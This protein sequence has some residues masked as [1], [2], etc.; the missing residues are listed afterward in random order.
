METV[1]TMQNERSFNWMPWIVCFSASL[2][3]FYEFIQGNMFASIADNIMQDFNIEVDKLAYLSS[4]YYLSNV[5]FLF[6]AGHLLD[7]YSAKKIMLLAMFLCVVSTFVLAEA[8]SFFI[9]LLC[10]F[11]TGVGSAFCLLGPVRIASRWFL[12]RQMAMVTGIIVTI[13]MLG[14]LAAQYPMTLLVSKIGWRNAVLVVG[15]IGV[16]MWFVMGF[17]I[18][19][20]PNTHKIGAENRLRFKE[21]FK[22]AYTNSAAIRVAL[23]ATLMNMGIA[24]FGAMMGSLYLM[25]RLDISKELAA[26]INGMIFLGTIFGGPLMGRWSDKLGERLVPM[27]FG[28]LGALITILIIL[29]LPLAPLVMYILF[30]ALGFFTSAQIISYAYV[31]ETQPASMTATA[32]SLVSLGT[33]IGYI[34]FQNLFSQIL[35]LHSQ[36]PGVYQLGDYQTAAIMLPIGLIFAF[37]LLIKLKETYCHNVEV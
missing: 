15:F 12:P 21:A 37:I 23:F 19:D 31:A 1:A 13:A 35:L 11:M 33:Q 2:F 9:A 26:S 22:R 20:K 30:F 10:R 5:M 32:V 34:I 3:F 36:R 17:G 28:A 27:R 16:T 14:G 29:Y 18:V 4:I 6:V 8:H 7:R 25:A 24:V